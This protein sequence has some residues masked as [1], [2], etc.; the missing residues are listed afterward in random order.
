MPPWK[1][2]ISGLVSFSRLPC[3]PYTP[4]IHQP[5]LTGAGKLDLEP[6]WKAHPHTHRETVEL[7]FVAQG[8]GCTS[9]GGT[10]FPIAAGDLITYNPGWE[11][12]EDFSRCAQPPLLYH[13]EFASLHIHGL[14]P[15]HM[16]PDGAPP[17]MPVGEQ[18]DDMVRCFQ[19]IFHECCRQTFGYEQILYARLETLVL[20]MMRLYAEFF[21]LRMI[22][23]TGDTNMAI[24]VKSYIDCNYCR[25]IHL[26]DIA[27]AMS[28][29]PYH[30]SHVFT[31]YYGLS[32]IRYLIGRRINEAKRMLLS[33]RLS[34]KEITARLGYDSISTFTAQFHQHTGTAPSRFRLEGREGRYEADN[35]NTWTQIIH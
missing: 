20:L 35:P 9:I 14:P 8:E 24:A 11:H 22:A 19:V 27:A 3:H 16:L 15:G 33:S 23:D 2:V 32:P 13:C 6:H 7:V 28:A 31:A 10:R 1:G 21:P 17:V 25:D 12:Y 30:I 26:H 34:I 29:S 5:V 18:R 4:I